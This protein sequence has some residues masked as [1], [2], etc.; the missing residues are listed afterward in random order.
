MRNIFNSLNKYLSYILIFSIPLT[1]PFV[2]LIAKLLFL[3]NFYKLK[4]IRKIDKII[5][6][7]PFYQLV[8]SLVYGKLFLFIKIPQGITPVL[9][10]TVRFTEIKIETALK[11]L[12]LGTCLL[13]ISTIFQSLF[14]IGNYKD[15]FSF[16]GKGQ[17]TIHIIRPQHTFLGHIL[18]VGAFLSVNVFLS[19]FFLIKEGGKK[20]SV[21][22][23]LNLI[24]LLL[25]FDRSYWISTFVTLVLI[26]IFL[27]CFK[28]EKKLMLISSL[29]IV[30][31]ILPVTTISFLKDRLSSIINIH[32]NSSNMYRIA[33]WRGGINY[34]LNA[35]IEE[36]LIGISRFHH[37]EN[38]KNY[39]E[40]EEVKCN[41]PKHIFSHLHSDFITILIWYGIIGL[42]LFLFTFGYLIFKNFKLFLTYGDYNF[43][44]F[45]CSY[46]T[47]LIS[48]IFEYNFEDESVKYLLY[49]LFALNSKLISSKAPNAA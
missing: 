18:T 28:K 30:S 14:G 11:F 6:L 19:F 31:L 25:T 27:G 26:S 7:M 17:L 38:L 40:K 15:L 9:S 36:K 46:I 22:T 34:F 10:Y 12:L 33:M 21:S 4:D 45:F 47:I 13:A 39:I 41:L 32:S 48:G 42:T 1:H 29:L 44:I 20:Y 2:R 3:L 16:L 37:K 43:L 24:A 49:I 35:S 8:Q 23:L 5:L